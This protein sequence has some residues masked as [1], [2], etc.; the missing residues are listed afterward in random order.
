MRP[1]NGKVIADWSN[2]SDMGLPHSTTLSRSIAPHSS[3][4]VVEC[5][6]KQDRSPSAEPR[7]FPPPWRRNFIHLMRIAASRLLG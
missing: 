2:K 3:R 5:G 6:K 4:E 1:L 7:S